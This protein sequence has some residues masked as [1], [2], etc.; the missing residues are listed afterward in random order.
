MVV[1]NSLGEFGEDQMRYNLEGTQY[2]T[3]LFYNI[4]IN[5]YL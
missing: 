2:L 3:E 5:K 4:T 1:S